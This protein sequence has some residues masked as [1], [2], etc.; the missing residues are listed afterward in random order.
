MLERT[1]GE[2]AA[3]AHARVLRR[4][5]RPQEA[6]AALE[7]VDGAE[8]SVP[9]LEA[10]AKL[11]EHI[12]R[13]LA[14][15]HAIATR[16]SALEPDAIRHARRLARLQRRIETSKPKRPAMDGGFKRTGPLEVAGKRRPREGNSQT[17]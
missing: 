17:V 14:K 13:D 6:Q 12:L 5:G 4:D 11:H 8:R 15:A 1:P 10:L 2:A 3:L 16:L 9:I 7:R